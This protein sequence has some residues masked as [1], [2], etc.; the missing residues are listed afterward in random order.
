MGPLILEEKE[1]GLPSWTTFVVEHKFG[2]P[3]PYTLEVFGELEV[4]FNGVEDYGR[5]ASEVLVTSPQRC[6]WNKPIFALQQ[7][8][9]IYVFSRLLWVQ[10]T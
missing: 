2:K 6:V 4:L 8:K 3:P 1:Q 10:V 5:L 7:K 9:G